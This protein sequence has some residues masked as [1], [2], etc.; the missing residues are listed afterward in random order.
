MNK[1]IWYPTVNWI[2][3]A[4]KRII[5]REKVTKAERHEIK[6]NG[7][8]KIENVIQES[9][10]SKGS[11]EHKASILLR[12]INQAHSFGSANKRTSYFIAKTFILKNKKVVINNEDKNLG[13]F[14]LKVRAGK[15]KD[16]DIEKFLNK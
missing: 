14:G 11:I 5:K 15:V 6:L 9:I 10:E 12:G 3:S 1:S 13:E 8:R 7:R 16:K 2:I 4:N